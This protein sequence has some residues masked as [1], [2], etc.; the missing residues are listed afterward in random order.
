MTQVLMLGVV[1]VHGL[2]DG[3][4]QTAALSDIVLTA[5]LADVFDSCVVACSSGS[6]LPIAMCACVM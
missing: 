4:E 3:P 2:T 6:E 5:D 1:A